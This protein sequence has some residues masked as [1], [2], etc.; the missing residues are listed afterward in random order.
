VLILTLTLG[1]NAQSLKMMALTMPRSAILPFAI[2]TSDGRH[3]FVSVTNVDAPNFTGPDSA[4]GARH[5][6]I[7]G[8]SGLS[9]R[10]P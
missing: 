6:V 5:D 9:G 4:A 1:A 8:N 2:F 10:A 3:I 7:S